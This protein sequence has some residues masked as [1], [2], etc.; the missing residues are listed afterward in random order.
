MKT[1]IIEIPYKCNNIHYSLNDIL[2]ANIVS[3]DQ[4]L[5][6]LM[7]KHIQELKQKHIEIFER[8]KNI[9]AT[10]NGYHCAVMEK[11]LNENSI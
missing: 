4:I 1:V 5:L 11:Y 7:D 9:I 8:I 10:E 3:D 6:L 2:D